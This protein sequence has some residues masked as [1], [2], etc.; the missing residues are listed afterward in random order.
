MRPRRG[1]LN[2]LISGWRVNGDR[3]GVQFLPRRELR[4]L[5]RRELRLLPRRELGLLPRREFR[6]GR[7]IG[8]RRSIRPCVIVLPGWQR[9]LRHGGR[10]LTGRQDRLVL[11]HRYR[12]AHRHRVAHR[13]RVANLYHIAHRYRVLK[14]VHRILAGDRRVERGRGKVRRHAEVWRHA[15]ILRGGRRRLRGRVNPIRLSQRDILADRLAVRA[16]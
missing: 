5:P 9:F 14:V 7:T 16:G 2:R 6:P 8:A 11:A 13:Y 15:K 10:V 12:V 1:Q 4:L 3:S